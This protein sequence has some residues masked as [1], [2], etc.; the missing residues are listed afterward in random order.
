MFLTKKRDGTMK[1]WACADGRQQQEFTNKDN[2]ASPT[3]MIELM[4]I[5]TAID[6]KE[7]R[8]VAIIDL[9][10]AFLHA[11]NNKKVIIFMKKKMAEL[12]AHVDLQIGQKYITMTKAGEKIT[13]ESPK[14]TIQN[15]E[16][17]IS[18]L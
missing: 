2:A 8:D 1:A 18:F 5:T 10:R 11:S 4:F 17:C 7:H 16:M 6:A 13:D 9:P 3:A 12:M 14:S 15:V